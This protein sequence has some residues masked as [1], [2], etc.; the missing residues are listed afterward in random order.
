MY[1]ALQVFLRPFRQIRI[2]GRFTDGFY[3]LAQLEEY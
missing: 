2:M 3:A 1:R